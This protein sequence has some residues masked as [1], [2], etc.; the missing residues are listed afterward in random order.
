[1][2]GSIQCF[3]LMCC[4]LFLNYWCI[5][6]DHSR[7][8]WIYLKAKK[9]EVVKLIK[10]FCQRLKPN[11]KVKRIWSDNGTEFT[12]LQ[13]YLVEYCIETSCVG[14]PTKWTSWTKTPTHSFQCCSCRFQCC[15][16]PPIS[17]QLTVGYLINRTP[18]PM[19]QNKTPYEIIFGHPLIGI[20]SYFRY[21]LLTCFI[22]SL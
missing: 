18:T 12:S 17:S 13:H 8:I 16:D 2:H 20:L 6:H 7:G 21:H 22:S 9:L 5:V 10:N 1:M 11:Y 3:F 14:T 19:L 4:L 15:S